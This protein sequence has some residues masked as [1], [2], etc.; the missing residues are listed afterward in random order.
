[1]HEKILIID[2]DENMCRMIQDYFKRKNYDIDWELDPDKAFQSIMNNDYK[3]ILLDIQIPLM[4]GIQLCEKIVS[5][6]P[7]IPVIII[8]AFGNFEN[9]VRALRSGAYNFLTKPVDLTYLEISIKKALEYYELKEQI[10][11]LSTKLE[12]IEIR[13][14][15]IGESTAM[16]K[17]YDLIGKIAK[18]ETAILI[19][20]ESGTGK[21]LIAKTIHQNSNRKN[22]L[23][24]T[25]NTSTLPENLLE[26]ELFGYKKGSFTDAKEDREGIFIQS[27]KGTIF[28]DEIGDMPINLQPKLLRVL[29]EKKVRPIGSGKEIT[30]DVRIIS[31]TNQDIEKLMKDG[32]FREDLFYRL[33]VIKI[34]IPPLRERGNDILN[35]SQ[36][37][38]N[39][40]SHK[41]NKE[42]KGL[43]SKT[44]EKLLYYNWPGNV[45]ELRNTIER[46]V[47]LTKFDNLTLED[48]PEN[49]KDYKSQN[50][51]N[52]IHNEEFITLDE[53][54][55]R[56]IT[57]VLK[58]CKNNYSKVSRILGIDRTT[59]Y[60]KIKQYKLE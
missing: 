25:L 19:T 12:K 35:L 57:D 46:A 23:F 2:D 28:L 50:K 20:G 55:K 45:R 31:A 37:F 51:L 41:F 17:I 7:G 59:L 34:E 44:A 15:I 8:T 10:K 54:E 33:N 48:L 9:A 40:F 29:E 30:V 38:I 14:N 43:L 3:L 32:K 47:A 13:D 60:R 27:D 21:E 42:V 4:D 58:S 11:I 1:M 5:N 6:R 16:K 36:Y 22:E 18:T 39:Q 56:H 26:S 49:I 53:L 52:H 24:I